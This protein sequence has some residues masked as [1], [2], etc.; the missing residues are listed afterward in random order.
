MPTLI[1]EASES[2]RK[3][4]KSVATMK[5]G[6]EIVIHFALVNDGPIDGTQNTCTTEDECIKTLTFAKN[7]LGLVCCG[8]SK[9]FEQA[10]LTNG[11]SAHHLSRHSVLVLSASQ[12]LSLYVEITAAAKYR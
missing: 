2:G 6:T 5:E 1:S 10:K 9:Q 3:V 12:I 8:C 11:F 4:Y 7:T